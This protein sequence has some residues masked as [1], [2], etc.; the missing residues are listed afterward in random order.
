VKK[1]LRCPQ[2]SRR[3]PAVV[4]ALLHI[5]SRIFLA[6]TGLFLGMSP[7]K[8]GHLNMIGLKIRGG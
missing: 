5:E 2:R 8:F 1:N 4:S 7:V 3:L 6:V